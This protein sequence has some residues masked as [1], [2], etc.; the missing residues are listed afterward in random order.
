MAPVLLP[1]VAVTPSV[2]GRDAAAKKECIDEHPW[3]VGSA[4]YATMMM[5]M[6]SDACIARESQR[7]HENQQ[8]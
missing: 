8:R 7:R 1:L 3:R 2:C 4:I 6:F 5:M